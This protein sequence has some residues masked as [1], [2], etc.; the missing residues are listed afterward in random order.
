MMTRKIYCVVAVL[1]LC[2]GNIFLGLPTEEEDILLNEEVENEMVKIGQII[3]V[4]GT[5][6]D[7]EDLQNF[8]NL[9]KFG[10]Y[11]YF[12]TVSTTHFKVLKLNSL[13]AN[14]TTA[15]DYNITVG[16]FSS[17][18]TPILRIVYVGTEW[19][20][21]ATTVAKDTSNNHRLLTIYKNL[22]DA[23]LSASNGTTDN[24]VIG[25]GAS[26]IW[27]YPIDIFQHDSTNL[28]DLEIFIWDKAVVGQYARFYEVNAGVINTP[29]VKSIGITITYQNAVYA[30]KS[31][32]NAGTYTFMG[33]N[34]ATYTLYTTTTAWAD[35]SVVQT[36]L[37]APATF[38]AYVQQYWKVGNTEI[39]MDQDHFY[40]RIS[41]GA[42]VSYSDVGTTT[43]AII[44]DYGASNEYIINYIIWKD[45]I[46]K[47]LQNGA[48]CKIQETT[49]DAYVGWGDWVTNG[50][51]TIYQ[52]ALSTSKGGLDFLPKKFDI[53]ENTGEANVVDGSSSIL[54]N[55]REVG[56]FYSDA[57]VLLHMGEIGPITGSKGLW[58]YKVVAQWTGDLKNKV[59]ESYTDKTWNYMLTDILTKYC[60]H[61][62]GL[63]I[64]SS[65]DEFSFEFK[66]DSVKKLLAAAC[67]QEGWKYYFDPAWKC[68][69]NDG[70]T[71][72]SVT[73][74]SS[75]PDFITRVTSKR[76]PSQ[77]G[78]VEATG[79]INPATG[80]KFRLRKPVPNVS[81]NQ[82]LFDAFPWIDN[83]TDLEDQ[84]DQ[85]IG[86]KNIMVEEVN[87]EVRGKG[88]IQVGEQLTFEYIVGNYNYTSDT[89]Y[90]TKAKYEAL[91]DVATLTIHD[92]MLME[93]PADPEKLF[94]KPPEEGIE[95]NSHLIEA[96]ASAI[97]VLGATSGISN[98]VEDTTPELGGSL[99]LN[100]K[101]IIITITHSVAS[102]SLVYMN[103][104]TP[105]L[106]DADAAATMPAIGISLGSNQIQTGGIYTTTGL[107][108]GS[109]YYTSTTG[110]LTTTKPSGVGDQVQRIGVALSTTR[111]LLHIS[112]DV[113]TV[114]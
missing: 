14:T 1:F 87:L 35:S 43:N 60:S 31:D 33:L 75:T 101:A 38:N 17:I 7:L 109:I 28:D 50:A 53:D 29:A 26:P 16:N 90:I 103:G 68:Y 85:I 9:G 83:L 71:A 56:I 46:Y 41:G 84:I 34:G 6:D 74:K 20:L 24:E 30:G 39:I 76:Y 94:D 40:S 91:S 65:T 92:A 70:S 2:V 64:A 104:A 78:F 48:I 88:F 77:I 113:L 80:L 18:L 114:S 45:S 13:T 81:S 54:W 21:L 63:S 86:Q 89:W 93:M 100:G 107:A 59:Y 62:N 32:Q 10:S 25:S 47:I 102:G 66:G 4:T 98:V 69:V 58:K 106:A 22:S 79:G 96:N 108:A 97:V 52:Y 11:Y 72:A 51:D 12:A 99:D 36:G 57:G 49:V 8:H 55:A 112:L 19:H 23:D 82:G 105:T 27:Q 73:V 37:T 42:W 111:L 44:W 67:K 3:A 61:F 110:T 95:E 5:N 15:H